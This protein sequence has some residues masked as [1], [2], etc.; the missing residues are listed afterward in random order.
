[1]QFTTVSQRAQSAMPDSFQAFGGTDC[2]ITRLCVRIHGPFD[3]AIIVAADHCSC[4]LICLDPMLQG[5][6]SLTA[7]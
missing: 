3:L 2:S 5:S 7:M 4:V 1:M 6:T